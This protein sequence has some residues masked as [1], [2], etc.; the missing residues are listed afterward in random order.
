[1]EKSLKVAEMVNGIFVNLILSKYRVDQIRG[2][3]AGEKLGANRRLQLIL[4]P[5]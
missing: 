2:I 3:L 1:M 5:F 4:A